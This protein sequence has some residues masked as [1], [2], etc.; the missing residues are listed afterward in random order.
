[1]GQLTVV[2]ATR[3]CA[4]SLQRCLD[5]VS[6]QQ[7]VRCETVVIDGASSDATPRLLAENLASGNISDYVS[8]SDSGV[9]S[10]FNKGVRRAR[11]EWICFLGCDDVLHDQ[12]V[13][14]DMLAATAAGPSSCSIVYGRVNLV[15]ADGA[16][17][18]TVGEPWDRAREAFLQGSSI[19][20]PGMLH[21]R[22]LF[23]A[24][25]PFDE[26]YRIAGD[27]ELLLRELLHNDPLFIDR[28]TVDMR[29]G[30]LSRHPATIPVVLDEVI[31]ARRQHGLGDAPP[32]LKRALLA[33]RAGAAICALLGRRTFNILADAGRVCRGKPRVW[34]R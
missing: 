22:S 4:S 28:I 6:G 13:L 8:E 29:V 34:T 2:V 23:E 11:G 3:N 9:Y 21:R 14:R 19:P 1:M 17:V 26:S 10:A 20:H 12:F 18:E 30:G 33:G 7:G 15:S 25:G 5:S 27:Y 16:V 31:R 32:R 24:R